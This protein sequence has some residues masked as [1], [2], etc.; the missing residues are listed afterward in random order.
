M[1]GS[2]GI[3]TVVELDRQI[4]HPDLESDLAMLRQVEGERNKAS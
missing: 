1:V 2:T 3:R 4:G